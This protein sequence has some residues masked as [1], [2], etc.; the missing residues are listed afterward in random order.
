MII[1]KNGSNFNRQGD[2]SR[3]WAIPRIPLFGRV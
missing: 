1:V 3:A 2:K